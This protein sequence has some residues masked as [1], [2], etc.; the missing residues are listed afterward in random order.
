M[1]VTYQSTNNSGWVDGSSTQ[2]CVVTK[3]SGLALNDIM[4]LLFSQEA[5]DGWGTTPSGWTQIAT[6]SQ[7]TVDE[8]M[9]NFVMYK[10]ADSSDVAATNFTFVASASSTT[11]AAALYRISGGDIS[12]SQV[13]TGNTDNQAYISVAGI[14]PNEE[15]S[16]FMFLNALSD[17]ANTPNNHVI[18]TGNTTW[19][20]VTSITTTL[21]V[22]HGLE[23]A[24]GNRSQKTNTGL[25]SS[26]GFPNGTDIW[27]CFL[28]IPPANPSRNFFNFIYN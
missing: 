5:V 9:Q 21:G 27:S 15:N 18:E 3:P 11:H 24:Y 26:D 22:D 2:N 7:G 14:T 20:I 8:V 1:A 17:Q 19:N 16:L 23:A 13:S 25:A 28:V 10:I 12:R 4:I 6:Y